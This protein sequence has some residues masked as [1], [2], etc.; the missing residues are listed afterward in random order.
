[1]P[2]YD[3]ECGSCGAIVERYAKI[4][5]EV[6]ACEKC[7]SEAH[8]IISVSGHYC[9]NEDAPWLKSVVEVVDKDPNKAHCQE[10][11]KNPTRRNWKAWMAGEG[12]K[13]APGNHHGGPPTASRPEPPDMSK[14]NREGWEKHQ[15]RMRIE[16]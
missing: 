4:E 13:P 15:K 16:V 1:M 14:A 3:F 2:I 7:N 9:G 6:L 10:F 8:R 5:E 12:I 11:I